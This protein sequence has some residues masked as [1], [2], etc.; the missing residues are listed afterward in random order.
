MSGHIHTFVQIAVIS[1][2]G[3]LIDGSV[4]RRL[5]ALVLTTLERIVSLKSLVDVIP[6]RYQ[7]LALFIV[8]C[9]GLVVD[10][11][12][13]FC[14]QKLVD[15]VLRLA[16]RIQAHVGQILESRR[17]ECV[18]RFCI[19]LRV[20]FLILRLRELI[21]SLDLCLNGFVFKDKPNLHVPLRLNAYFF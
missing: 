18:A 1:S 15:L 9:L 14:F 3:V 7:R 16:L 10:D 19:T 12:L 11:I 13:V 6:L 17:H 2:L 4:L 5:D 8:A 20:L 21:N